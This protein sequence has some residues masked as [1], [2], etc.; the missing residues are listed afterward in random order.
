MAGL[1]VNTISEYIGQNVRKGPHS[2][3]FS[4]ILLWML[5]C[6]LAST[7]S[8]LLPL[9][10]LARCES[11]MLAHALVSESER[12]RESAVVIELP[13]GGGGVEI[14]FPRAL[15]RHHRRGESPIQQA[16]EVSETP[17][18]FHLISYGTLGRVW[19]LPPR[20][21]VEESQIE[22]GNPPHKWF[23]CRD[24]TLLLSWMHSLLVWLG[25]TNEKWRANP[26][27]TPK[28]CLICLFFFKFLYL[29]F[30]VYVEFHVSIVNFIPS[31]SFVLISMFVCTSFC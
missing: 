20:V 13:Y 11:C 24:S 1:G 15:L 21:G 29:A 5:V 30:H 14:E 9:A 7:S 28:N 27:K 23:R 25:F 17:C 4:C 12:E 19:A 10:C 16:R 18:L 2:L 8:S 22:R 3:V 26:H 31:M 6:A